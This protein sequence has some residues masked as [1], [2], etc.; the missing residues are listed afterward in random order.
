MPINDTPEV[1]EISKKGLL[2][3]LREIPKEVLEEICT[4]TN[5]GGK[6]KSRVV[7]CNVVFL[8]V[9]V[10]FLFAGWFKP[11]ERPMPLKYDYSWVVFSLISM[12][13]LQYVDLSNRLRDIFRRRELPPDKIK[14]TSNAA[15]LLRWTGLFFII[16]IS[17]LAIRIIW[18]S[19]SPEKLG[20]LHKLIDGLEGQEAIKSLEIL[21]RVFLYLDWVIIASFILGSFLRIVVFLHSYFE[22]LLKRPWKDKPGP[23]FD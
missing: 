12:L 18:L 17:A 3:F 5:E 16:T 9:V 7:F 19:F 23:E 21:G 15:F 13:S 22:D 1:V 10:I 14:K 4:E 20:V 11:L 8:V 2:S 6:N